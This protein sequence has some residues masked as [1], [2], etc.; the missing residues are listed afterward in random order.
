MLAIGEI[1]VPTLQKVRFY[2]AK[3]LL[4]NRCN[5]L[6]ERAEFLVLYL[7]FGNTGMIKFELLKLN[8]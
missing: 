7:L 3:T 1:I 5:D 2:V 8:L 4:P 6:N